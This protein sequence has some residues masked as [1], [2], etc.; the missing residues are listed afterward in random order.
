MWDEWK[1]GE[2]ANL[3]RQGKKDHHKIEIENT[4]NGL[5]WK[6]KKTNSWQDAKI[7]EIYKGVTD[8][9]DPH[10]DNEITTTQIYKWQNEVLKEN[11][12]ECRN[13]ENL[14]RQAK[15]IALW[16]QLVRQAWETFLEA[17]PKSEDGS[18]LYIR[19]IDPQKRILLSDLINLAKE[20]NIVREK[21]YKNV[22][23][24][25]DNS[26]KL[27]QSPWKTMDISLSWSNQE[28][29]TEPPAFRSIRHT[30]LF[31]KNLP[32]SLPETLDID[33]EEYDLFSTIDQVSLD[34]CPACMKASEFLRKYDEDQMKKDTASQKGHTE[35]D[36]N[37]LSE[38]LRSLQEKYDFLQEEHE[39]MRKQNELLQKELDDLRKS[40]ISDSQTA[41]KEI[42][43]EDQVTEYCISAL[44]KKEAQ[45]FCPWFS[46]KKAD[47][48]MEDVLSSDESS[49]P[50]NIVI[51]GGMS[52]YSY[53]QE[54]LEGNLGL[55]ILKKGK[56]NFQ[57]NLTEAERMLKP[58]SL[59]D[60]KSTSSLSD[61]INNEI[62]ESKFNNN[63]FI[64]NWD[65]MSEDYKKYIAATILYKKDNRDAYPKQYKDVASYLR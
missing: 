24:N 17:C 64:T 41:T 23:F 3:A 37:S 59:K 50:N 51:E 62:K 6:D 16:S 9:F 32:T 15:S 65:S 46:R 49:L 18:Q 14:R 8:L 45:I 43:K 40:L 13:P 29:G 2:V 53:V 58:V 52:L 30:P 39:D 5:S 38:S 63:Q 22:T 10:V 47:V 25:S 36:K 11:I 57:D 28:K 55:D 60:V 26:I 61:I 7:T 12:E 27:E 42:I 1:A 19:N 56:D 21:S 34:S 44:L 48:F 35:E 4:M 54:N 31:S 33:S 20:Y